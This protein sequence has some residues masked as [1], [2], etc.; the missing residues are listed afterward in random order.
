MSPEQA[1]GVSDVD[2]RTDIYGLGCVLYEM[3]VGRPPS[4]G[5]TP[6]GHHT[7]GPRDIRNGL[8]AVRP[9]IPSRLSE[10]VVRAL[11]EAPA[12]RFPDAEQFG[13]ALAGTDTRPLG[14]LHRMRRGGALAV[15]GLV[16]LAI[17]GGWLV[18]RAR[19][20]RSPWQPI[21]H[22]AVLYFDDIS[23]DSSS[24]PWRRGSRRT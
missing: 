7:P 22:V 11:A 10:V 2:G 15:S 17:V 8:S 9:P 3:L 14:R 4:G 18:E 12:D 24:A 1:Y 21:R 6:G 20:G 13:A 19:R 23:P 5:T 16:V